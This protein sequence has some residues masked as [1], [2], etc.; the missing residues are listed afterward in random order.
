[1]HKSLFSWGLWFLW[2]QGSPPSACTGLPVV[3]SSAASMTV[4]GASGSSGDNSFGGKSNKMKTT[5]WLRCPGAIETTRMSRIPT[6]STLSESS[7]HP[8]LS[9]DVEIQSE[10]YSAGD[11]PAA[12]DPAS[13][14]D[15]IPPSGAKSQGIRQQIYY[16]MDDPSYNNVAKIYS[17]F[18]MLIILMST[19]TFVLESEASKE[20]GIMYGD[21]DNH[22]A[23]VSLC[24]SRGYAWRGVRFMPRGRD[25]RWPMIVALLDASG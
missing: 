4:S 21:G 23:K 25:T 22:R 19:V 9:S 8:E 20:G 14:K 16:I 18:I 12:A 10:E 17:I 1:M 2:L 7:V 3:L 11:A 13:D 5:D 24:G 15:T 6:S